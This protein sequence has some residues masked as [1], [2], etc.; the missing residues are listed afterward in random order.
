[1]A[2]DQ[3]TLQGFLFIIRDYSHSDLSLNHSQ[4]SRPVVDWSDY[5]NVFKGLSRT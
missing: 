1:M 5:G 3:V 2:R 4:G